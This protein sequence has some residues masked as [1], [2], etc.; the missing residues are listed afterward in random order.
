MGSH[1]LEF[2]TPQQNKEWSTQQEIFSM[3]HRHCWEKF[4]RNKKNMYSNIFKE[5]L[6]SLK[7]KD[8]ESITL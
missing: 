2:G 5:T 1:S 3:K 8:F 6:P 4:M 7:K